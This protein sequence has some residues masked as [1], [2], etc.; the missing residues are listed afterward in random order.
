MKFGARPLALALAL[1]TAGCATGPQRVTKLVGDRIVVTR[2][3]SPD[4]YE[5]VARARLFEED[6]RWNDAAAELQRALAFDP[7]AAEVRAELAELFLRTGRLDDAAEQIDRSLE[8]A[9]TVD[10][11]LARAH[12][13]DARHDGAVALDALKSAVKA[14]LADDDPEAAERAHLALS[15]AQI[16]ALDL[17]AALE[18]LRG[19]ERVAPETLR[20]REQHGALAWALGAVDES[21]AALTAALAREPGD[22][23]A[24]LMLGELQAAVGRAKEAKATFTEAIDRAEVPLAVAAAIA[25]WLVE[26]GEEPEA[27]ELADRTTANVGD[28][29]GLALASALERVAKRPARAAELAERAIQLGAAPGRA[30]VLRA[31]ARFAAGDHAGAVKLLLGVPV[32]APEYVSARLRAAEIL[33]EDRQLDE[34]E[35]ALETAARRAGAPDR[36]GASEKD[37]EDAAS[38]AIAR[39]QVDERRGDAVRAARRLDEALAAEPDDARLVLARAGVDDR[40]GDWRA[41]LVRAEKLLARDPRSVEA[42]NFAGFVAAD[43]AENLPL[44]T[45]RLQAAVALSPGVGGVIDSL[46]WAYFRAGDLPRAAAFLEQAMRLEPGDAEILEHVGDLYVKRGERSR[47]LEAYRRAQGLG[48]SPEVARDLAE[49]VRTLEAKSAAGR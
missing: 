25:G 20:G 22:V 32:D 7:D 24:R 23:E 17:P 10:G 40:R 8:A 2:A 48:P 31:E 29:D 9:P 19:L 6:E 37:R 26:R 34:A 18:T 27:A 12:L 5:H 49:R 47:A 28:V 33:R 4:A 43:H 15:D 3:V 46:G 35:L 45:K 39:S 30:A 42:L 14:A 41:A 38:I 36:A 21:E 16:V 1:G 11:Y 13:A 44:A